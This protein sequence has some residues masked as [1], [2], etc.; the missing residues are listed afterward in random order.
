LVELVLFGRRL[1]ESGTVPDFQA[2]SDEIIVGSGLA[3]HLRVYHI[4]TIWLKKW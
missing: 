1:D 4:G 2:D 3:G